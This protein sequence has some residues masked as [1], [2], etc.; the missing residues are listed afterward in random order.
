[1]FKREEHHVLL[2]DIANNTK[3]QDD[4]QKRSGHQLVKGEVQS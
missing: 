1:M 2:S 3:V 4:G